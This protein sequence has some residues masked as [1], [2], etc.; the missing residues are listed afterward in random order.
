MITHIFAG[1]ASV[2]KGEDYGI[3]MKCSACI[4]AERIK[5]LQEN[6]EYL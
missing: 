4:G 2:G 3:Y 6:P 5:K 1:P